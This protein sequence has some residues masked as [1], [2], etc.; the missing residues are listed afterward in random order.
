M[1]TRS[2]FSI[3]LLSNPFLFYAVLAPFFTQLAFSYVPA[4]QW[5]FRTVPPAVEKWAQIE[6]ISVT[7]IIAAEIGKAIRRYKHKTD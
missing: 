6:V 5:V 4:L 3:S 1:N 2:I 7:V